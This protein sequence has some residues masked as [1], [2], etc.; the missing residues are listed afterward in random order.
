[1][2]GLAVRLAPGALLVLPPPTICAYKIY[3][4]VAERLR[5]TIKTFAQ[6]CNWVGVKILNDE[7]ER[8]IFRNF[9]MASIIITEDQLFDGF[10]IEF[11]FSFFRNYLNSQN[12]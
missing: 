7:F 12:I 4:K 11:I 2:F 6:T 1:M 8:L 3:N 5:K 9:K 10:I